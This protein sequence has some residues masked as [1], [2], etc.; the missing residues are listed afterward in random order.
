MPGA[1][2]RERIWYWD[3]LRIAAVLCLV[4]RHIST[5]CFD[6]VEPLGFRWWVLG[7][8]ALDE[9]NSGYVPWPSNSSMVASIRSLHEYAALLS[10]D[11]SLQA[12]V[13]PSNVL[14]QN[15]LELLAEHFEDLRVFAGV[16]IGT[17]D[18]LVQEFSAQ[19]NGVV[20][21]PRLTADMQM[22][23]SEWW[24]QINALNFQFVESNYIHPDDILDEERNDGGDFGKAIPGC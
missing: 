18:Q 23:D 8:Y 9:K 19:E 3:I 21:V 5:A 20:F 11:I 7:G 4:I 2:R 14:D 13:A 24:T 22:E 15:G 1:V 12:Y 16:Y 17:F 6:F 10:P